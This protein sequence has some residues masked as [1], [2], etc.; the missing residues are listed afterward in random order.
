M[1]ESRF[2]VTVFMLAAITAASASDALAEIKKPVGA[3]PVRAKPGVSKL[4]ESE[5]LNAKGMLWERAE[6]ASGVSCA[7]Q[8]EDKKWHYVCVTKQ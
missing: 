7:V 4:S 5:C 6:C 8:D 3:T 1:R 2:I